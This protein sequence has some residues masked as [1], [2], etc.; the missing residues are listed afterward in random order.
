MVTSSGTTPMVTRISVIAIAV[1]L[2]LIA[3][4][5]GGVPMLMMSCGMIVVASVGARMLQTPLSFVAMMVLWQVFTFLSSNTYFPQIHYRLYGLLGYVDEMMVI[6]L[7]LVLGGRLISR[8]NIAGQPVVLATVILLFVTLLSGLLN[9]SSVVDLLKYVMAYY[10]YV[11]IFVAAATLFQSTPKGFRGIV[12]SIQ[13]ILVI[14]LVVNVS[15][16]IGMPILPNRFLLQTDDWAV[17]TMGLSSTMS[18]AALIGLSLGLAGMSTATD[19]R[20][21][22]HGMVVTAMGVLLMAVA[23]TKHAVALAAPQLGL[24][25][26][27]SAKRHPVRK[28]VMVLAVVGILGGVAETYNR[29]YRAK[30]LSMYESH[31][32][33]LASQEK[34]RVYQNVGSTLPRENR[35]LLG[36]GPGR[37]SSVV[38]MWNTTP[39][40]LKHFYAEIYSQRYNPH[41]SIMLYPRSGVLSLLGDVGL[42]GLA[43][44]LSTLAVIAMR[45]LRQ[46]KH[47]QYDGSPAARNLAICW[48]GWVTFFVLLN[49]IT[50][51]LNFG[52]TPL[53]TFAWG[54]VVWNPVKVAEKA[55]EGETKGAADDESVSQGDPSVGED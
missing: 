8:R 16:M 3:P 37:Y 13:W 45:V 35:W 14:Q 29:V 22:F 23:N 21:R 52:L 26:F 17:G 33:S 10:R 47:G 6:P 51:Y 42:L 32:I 49:F 5:L 34:L 25:A 18:Y 1:I 44:Y 28:V 43:C 48:L 40:F 36:M 50:D 12:L 39:L 9:G 41:S 27:L 31:A 46:L 20:R 24:V 53:L 19:F 4:G 55:V 54:G 38:A 30:R 11:I 2:I 15:F 7:V